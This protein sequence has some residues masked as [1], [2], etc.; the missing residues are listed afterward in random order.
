MNAEIK[1]MNPRQQSPFGNETVKET[2]E[3]FDELFGPSYVEKYKNGEYTK[4]IH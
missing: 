3:R 4:E 2:K 1:K